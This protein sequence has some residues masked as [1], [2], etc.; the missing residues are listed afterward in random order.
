MT[1]RTRPMIV[2]DGYSWFTICDGSLDLMYIE[3][4]RG[5]SPGFSIALSEFDSVVKTKF[6]T[7]LITRIQFL[8][9]R[10]FQKRTRCN[11]AP[12]FQYGNASDNPMPDGI[13][14]ECSCA[15]LHMSG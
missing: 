4:A 6:T 2:L 7:P 10:L 9:H 3:R 11:S 5:Q 14:P 15:L 1:N 13:L 12:R 8:R